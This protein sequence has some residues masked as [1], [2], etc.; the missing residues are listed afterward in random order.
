MHIY[1]CVYIYIYIQYMVYLCLRFSR[2]AICIAM[3]CPLSGC[4]EA[5]GAPNGMYHLEAQ[6]CL[7]IRCF[8]RFPKQCLH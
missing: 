7:S 1:T 2:V 5:L 3:S 6:G 4:F 8:Q